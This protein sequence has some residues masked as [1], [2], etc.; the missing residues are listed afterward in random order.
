MQK[1]SSILF[2]FP[3]SVP[4]QRECRS[5]RIIKPA[6]G[7][8]DILSGLLCCDRKAIRIIVVQHELHAV[9]VVQLSR[10]H[11]IG[12]LLVIFVFMQ[13]KANRQ[14]NQIRRRWIHFDCIFFI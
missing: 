5:I 4:D 6:E 13:S 2:N 3:I 9:A 11:I 12:F 7:Q 14:R 8:G 1:N 10:D